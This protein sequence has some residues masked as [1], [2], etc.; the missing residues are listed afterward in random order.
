[1]QSHSMW[2]CSGAEIWTLSPLL[3]QSSRTPRLDIPETWPFRGRL[4]GTSSGYHSWRV[5]KEYCTSIYV[6]IHQLHHM[7]VGSQQL[8]KY[9]KIPCE[10][11]NGAMGAQ[12]KLHP[13]R[14]HMWVNAS[15]FRFDFQLVNV[16]KTWITFGGGCLFSITCND[17]GQKKKAFELQFMP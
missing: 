13:L 1:M 3:E 7:V 15:R 8:E 11:S 6:N 10:I 4:G 17:V 2:A 9:G 5:R 12:K 14:I 16:L